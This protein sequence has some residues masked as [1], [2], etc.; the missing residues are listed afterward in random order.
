LPPGLAKLSAEPEPMV[1][2]IVENDCPDNAVST[3]VTLSFAIYNMM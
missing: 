2:D 1:G 3:I